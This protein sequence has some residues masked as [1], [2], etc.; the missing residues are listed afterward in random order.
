MTLVSVYWSRFQNIYVYI[1]YMY[2]YLYLPNIFWNYKTGQATWSEY[3]TFVFLETHWS[4]NNVILKHF[5]GFILFLTQN[6]TI[7]PM[8]GEEFFFW[9]IL[10][11]DF[12]HSQNIWKRQSGRQVMKIAF[13]HLNCCTGKLLVLFTLGN[14]TLNR[15]FNVA[16]NRTVYALMH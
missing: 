8:G 7:F 14:K 2:M 16:K 9:K 6:P 4:H 12:F 15:L 10:L 3:C 5:K 11:I 13:F 1:Y